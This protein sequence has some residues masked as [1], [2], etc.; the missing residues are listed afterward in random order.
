[1]KKWQLAIAFVIILGCGMLIQ[2]GNDMQEM[3]QYKTDIDMAHAKWFGAYMDQLTSD[4]RTKNG[5]VYADI[6]YLCEPILPQ[7]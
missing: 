5:F 6:T 4:C 7:Q 1:M 3:G 2:K